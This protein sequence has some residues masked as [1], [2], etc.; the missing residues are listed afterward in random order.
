[1]GQTI[2]TRHRELTSLGDVASK[3]AAAAISDA[4]YDTALEWLE[5]GRSIVWNQLL[6]LHTLV[7]V[8]C[9]VQPS[10]ADDLVRISKALEHASNQDV[11]MQS[12]Q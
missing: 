8:L 11:F 6:Q 12:D 2:R 5:Q 7:N 1:L 10:L 3:A 9:E 4:R